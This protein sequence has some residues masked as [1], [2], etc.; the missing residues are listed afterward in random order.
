MKA[1]R[2]GA[3]VGGLV[4]GWIGRAEKAAEWWALAGGALLVAVVLLTAVSAAGNILLDRPVPG[5]FEVVE[6]AVAVAVFAFLP[7]CQFTG[8]NVAADIFT[9][10]LGPRALAGL[11]LLSSLVAAGF[12]AL[13]LWRMSVGMLNYRADGETT[14]ILGFPV[15]LAFPP[16]LLSLAL[17]LAAGAATAWKAVAGMR[18][19]RT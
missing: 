4:G 11:A 5:D 8:A 18:R 9:S 17:L 3:W 1:A 19:I 14:H 13:L 15:W 12:A 16:M 2:E 7:H 6:I 10:R